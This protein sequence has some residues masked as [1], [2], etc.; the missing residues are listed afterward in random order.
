[1]HGFSKG[2][3]GIALAAA[4]AT[5][6][7]ASGTN[8][9]SINVKGSAPEV[10]SL[11]GWTYV[12]GPG[13]FSGGTNA[14]VTYTN[15]QLVDSLANSVLG[16]G[17]AMTLQAPLLCNTAI[18]WSITTSKG[19]LRLDSGTTP[20][21]GFANQW[22]YE[23]KSGPYKSSGVAVASLEVDDADGTPFSGESHGLT[24]DK[25]TQIAYFGLSFT[26]FA[27]STRMLAGSYSESV[28]LTV[29]PSL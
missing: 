15:D 1:M 20:P 4:T 6:A 11:G 18:S 12:S 5:A 10:C 27:Q 25:A 22:L 19:A 21:T 7:L 3:W 26:P 17:A 29:S 8:P 24:S 23:L 14:V 16:P 2:L 9:D 28:T 13:S